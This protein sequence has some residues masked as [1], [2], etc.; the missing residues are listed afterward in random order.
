M[1]EVTKTEGL[2]QQPDQVIEQM[3]TT[4]QLP[5]TWWTS[6][7]TW[8]MLAKLCGQ[9]A[10]SNMVPSAYRD[11]PGNVMVAMAAGLPL[12]LSPLACLQSVAVINGKPTLYGDAPIAQVLAHPSL[13]EIKETHGG[14]IKGGD[15]EWS[16]TITR[17]MSGGNKQSVCRTF[18]IDDAKRAGLWGKTGPWSSYPDRML[19]NRARA[20]AV[21]DSFADVL[22]GVQ[23][24]AD[25]TEE[26]K[27]A[28]A[29]VVSAPP[30][31][32]VDEVSTLAPDKQE[33]VKTPEE[34]KSIQLAKK[35]KKKGG[36]IKKKVEQVE[37]V[38]HNTPLPLFTEP[39]E[40]TPIPQTVQ[41]VSARGPIEISRWCSDLS[42]LT[43]GG[44]HYDCVADILQVCNGEGWRVLKEGT[45]DDRFRSLA[46]HF[47]REAY[48]QE[49]TKYCKG[50]GLDKQ[51]ALLW[52]QD[53]L[54][55]D[56]TPQSFKDMPAQQ[57]AELV[58]NVT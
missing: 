34:T 40:D 45:T 16:I 38:G 3:Q 44:V 19:F 2:A 18:S 20:F 17:T 56:Q 24:M 49:L 11:E 9:F 54:A 8:Q 52:A 31:T 39:E 5:Q 22:Q 30:V 53:Q 35:R 1:N 4:G 23:L 33:E 10:N 46:F 37:E 36:P 48:A 29:T 43:S 6:N 50:R 41:A 42:T 25:N 21:R 28:E 15:R 58:L 51:S 27:K 47:L 32:L 13:H 14:S 57:L 7:Q 55:L 26:V 12:G